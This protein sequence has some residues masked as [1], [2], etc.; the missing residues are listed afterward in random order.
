MPAGLL[1]L[2]LSG[3]LPFVLPPSREA[4][5]P[6]V[7]VTN[8]SAAMISAAWPDSDYADLQS[9]GRVPADR[10][11]VDALDPAVRGGPTAALLKFDELIGDEAGQVP[12]GAVVHQALLRLSTSRPGDGAALHR[13]RLDWAAEATWNSFDDGIQ[14]DG[15]EAEAQPD[16]ITDAVGAGAIELDVTAGVQRWADGVE[17]YGWV[18]LPSGPN[19][20][21]FWGASAADEPQRPRLFVLFSAGDEPLSIASGDVTSDSVVLW[22]H[23]SVPGDVIFELS[24]DESLAETFATMAVPVS[25]TA[26]PAKLDVPLPAADAR[27]YYRATDAGGASRVGTF[28]SAAAPG[29]RRGLRFAVTGDW[30]GELSPY[31]AITNVPQ[32]E[33][34]LY[35]A[36]GDTIYADVASPAVPKDQCETLA[37]FRT[38]H[39]ETYLERFGLRSNAD[40][41]ASTAWFSMIDDHEVT[42]DFAGGAPPGSDPRF[43]DYPGDYINETE[44]FARGLQAFQEFH[45][46][47]DEYYGDTGD[48]R[49]AF[50]RKLFRFRTFGND[51]ALI[52]A[53]ARSFRDEEIADVFEIGVEQWFQDA[54][55][56]GRTM[57]GEAQLQDVQDALLAA[58]AQGVTWKFVLIPEPVQNLGPILGE[59]RYEGYAWERTRLLQFIDE[60]DI[61]NVVF[62]AADIHCTIVNNLAYQLEPGGASI[63][64][65]AWE[66]ST[67]AVAYSPPFGPVVIDLFAEVFPGFGPLLQTIYYRLDRAQQDALL[68]RL[69]DV[70]LNAWDYDPIGLDG[71]GIPATLLAGQWVSLN[72]YGWSEFEIDADTQQLRVTTYGI[73]WYDADELLEN[74]LDIVGRTPEVVSEFIVDAVGR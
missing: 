12:L 22:A 5:G 3:C 66:I 18:F 73:D 29:A 23:A 40:C 51:A 72:T 53:D 55:E 34:D 41:R 33:L 16:L 50:K 65:D 47:R 44:L 46:I 8:A 38:K 70:L 64:L 52:Q 11:R 1:T 6:I 74:P 63:P 9:D 69:M 62:V 15:V 10:L 26:V 27:Y 59:D 71:S 60:H 42:N 2:V 58:E 21:D 17:N 28:R 61:R 57:L 35:V 68:T 13:M 67:G 25:D 20:W 54:F 48:A 24:F 31:P 4:G 56:P 14:A 36:L 19:G 32:R 39:A 30:R 49:T 45:P 43:E 37:D 7:E